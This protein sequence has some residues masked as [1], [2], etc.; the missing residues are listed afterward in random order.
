MRTSATFVGS[1][2]AVRIWQVSKA[3]GRPWPVVVPDDDFLDYM[4]MEAVSAK[5]EREESKARKEVEREEWKK[6]GK[7]E[8]DRY[9]R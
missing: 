8:L 5:V 1:S 7:T 3:A 4:V 2:L 9:R 6:R